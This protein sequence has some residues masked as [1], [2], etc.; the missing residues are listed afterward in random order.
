MSTSGYG[1]HNMTF[2]YDN[3]ND[4][5]SANNRQSGSDYRILGTTTIV[6]GDGHLSGLQRRGWHDAH[7]VESDPDPERGI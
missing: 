3:F 5:R 7:P 1:S 6:R 2:G 4:I